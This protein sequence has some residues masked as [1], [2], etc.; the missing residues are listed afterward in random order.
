MN[1][2]PPEWKFT[3]VSGA[4]KEL[5]NMELFH[6]PGMTLIFFDTETTGVDKEKDPLTGR[7]IED[8]PT[9]VSAQKYLVEADGGLTLI[10]SLE[11]YV[12][13]SIPVP[14]NV[15][16]ITG[17][18]NEFLKDKPAW[19]EV[20]ENIRAF[21]GNH[22]VIAHN[23]P[24]DVKFM[25][26]MYEREGD[27]F[28]PAGV[29]DTLAIARYLYPEA[30]SRRLG[31]MI[32][33][34]Q[35]QYKVDYLCSGEYAYHNATYDVVALR[36]LYESLRQGVPE[37]RAKRRFV[38]YIQYGYYFHGYNRYQP[39]TVFKTSA[40]KI[41]YN[42]YFSKWVSNEVDLN[43][44]DIGKFEELALEYTQC[45]DMKELKKFRDKKEA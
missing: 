17:I 1:V 12:K 7:K 28:N 19:H 35:V 8:E 40:G 21:F 42:H 24:F 18:T 32:E 43:M 22:V 37:N 39:A 9:E 34:L 44:V 25:S 16:E 31:D 14:Q 45:A 3:C 10:D 2:S 41:E 26:R 13:P 15:E 6:V 38:P 33:L 36:V 27:Q 4:T 23:A 29:I 20:H 5:Q 30:K 11:V